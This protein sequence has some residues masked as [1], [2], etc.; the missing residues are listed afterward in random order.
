MLQKNTFK[1][2]F[3]LFKE[4]NNGLYQLFAA[5]PV[6]IGKFFVGLFYGLLIGFIFSFWK[7]ELFKNSIIIGSTIWILSLFDC[8][9]INWDTIYRIIGYSGSITYKMIVNFFQTYCLEIIVSIIVAFLVY[10]TVIKY[11]NR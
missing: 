1:G 10:A 8:V 11:I 6:Y 5:A 9:T 4:F 7:D 2:L 3:P